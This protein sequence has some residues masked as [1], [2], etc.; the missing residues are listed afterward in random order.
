TTALK[1][2]GSV[3]GGGG[4]RGFALTWRTTANALEGVATGHNHTLLARDGVAQICPFDL[5]QATYALANGQA[6][7]RMRADGEIRDRARWRVPI[8]STGEVTLAERTR[9]AGP[10]KQ[11]RAGQEVRLVDLPA[12][13]D[14]GCGIFDHGGEEQ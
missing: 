1:V 10:M 8:L 5:D 9:E 13:A 11:V 2:A 14:R 6:K 4:E 3:W 7:A 12:E